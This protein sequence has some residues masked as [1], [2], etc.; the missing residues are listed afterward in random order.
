MT[1]QE[2]RL[3]LSEQIYEAQKKQVEA[4]ALLG[5]KEIALKYAIEV[6]DLASDG[7]KFNRKNMQYMKS[8]ADVVEINEYRGARQLLRN[9]TNEYE[10]ACAK[11][12][13]L[14]MEVQYYNNISSAAVQAIEV[15]RSGLAQFGRLIQWRP[16]D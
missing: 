16:R 11:V 13:Q 9:V 14:R 3:A 12:R 7:V 4:D 8:R 1:N 10:A 15:A 5:Q 2:E 6:R